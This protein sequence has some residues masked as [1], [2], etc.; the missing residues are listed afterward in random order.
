MENIIKRTVVI[1]TSYEILVDCCLETI[2]VEVLLTSAVVVMFLIFVIK[3]S[4]V[5]TSVLT[6][7][8]RELSCQSLSR[9]R[10]LFS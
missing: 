9:S 6:W 4:S 1:E 7:D 10:E 5:A 2:A 8:H 3:N